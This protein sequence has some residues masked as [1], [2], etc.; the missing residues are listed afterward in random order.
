MFKCL[1]YLINVYI[2]S[3]KLILKLYIGFYGCMVMKNLYIKIL[4]WF[5]LLRLVFFI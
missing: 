3:E 4:K 2:G 1:C 5:D